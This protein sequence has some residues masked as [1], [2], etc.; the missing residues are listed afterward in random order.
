MSWIELYS[1]QYLFYLCGNDCKIRF[2]NKIISLEGIEAQTEDNLQNSFSVV[3][4]LQESDSFYEM[5]HE[6]IDYIE[7]KKTI[8]VNGQR[9]T[10]VV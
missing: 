8:D 10:F 7:M 5:I 1:Y 4:L 9:H 6:R 3:G 2:E